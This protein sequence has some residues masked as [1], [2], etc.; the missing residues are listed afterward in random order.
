MW[1]W[2]LWEWSVRPYV[3]ESHLLAEVDFRFWNAVETPRINC[4][5]LDQDAQWETTRN[6]VTSWP[7]RLYNALVTADWEIATQGARTQL[8]DVVVPHYNQVAVKV[9]WAAVGTLAR[10]LEINRITI[11]WDRFIARVGRQ[12]GARLWPRLSTITGDKNTDVRWPLAAVWL[13]SEHLWEAQVYIWPKVGTGEGGSAGKPWL[14]RQ[15]SN[16]SSI[17]LGFAQ[18]LIFFKEFSLVKIT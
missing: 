9:Y 10:W 5:G 13:V 11:S 17:A 15:H 16:H 1:Q 18:P 6:L 14:D 3:E 12:R 2:G 8:R 4:L 7:E